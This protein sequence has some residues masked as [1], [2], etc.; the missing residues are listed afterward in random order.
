MPNIMQ[1]AGPPQWAAVPQTYSGSYGPIA[2]VV[3]GGSGGLPPGGGSHAPPA[4]LHALTAARCTAG[5]NSPQQRRPGA[6]NTARQS[7]MQ[8]LAPAGATSAGPP[9]VQGPHGQPA[10]A[11][12]ALGLRQRSLPPAD[13]Q[14]TLGGAALSM[15]APPRSPPGSPQ[16]RT[17]RATFPGGS[18]GTLG[19]AIPPPAGKRCSSKNKNC[20]HE[21]AQ[22]VAQQQHADLISDFTLGNAL[23]GC[24]TPQLAT[25]PKQP[26]SFV[27]SLRAHRSSAPAP[28]GPPAGCSMRASG[29]SAAAP[30]GLRSS[31]SISPGPASRSM[32]QMR[33]YAPGSGHNAAS[34]PRT[35]GVSPTRVNGAGGMSPTRVNGA[36]GH[37]S[38][39]SLLPAYS[40]GGSL[41]AAAG[42]LHSPERARPLPPGIAG[43]GISLTSTLGSLPATIQP[44]QIPQPQAAVPR[45]L[46]VHSPERSFPA[47][48]ALAPAPYTQRA[49]APPVSPERTG[50]S[51]CC[52]IHASPPHST[53]PCSL[54]A[55][56]LTA[57]GAPH[58]LR[59]PGQLS[60][61]RT[62]NP[63][64]HAV[65]SAPF[66]ARNSAPP[67]TGGF[68]KQAAATAN[69][70][71]GQP[72]PV[73]VRNVGDPRSRSSSLPRAGEDGQQ[74]APPLPGMSASSS[75]S[76][77]PVQRVWS[78]ATVP[79]ECDS[80]IFSPLP[81]ALLSP[82]LVSRRVSHQSGMGDS[83]AASVG[84]DSTPLRSPRGRASSCNPAPSRLLS[85]GLSDRLS[86]DGQSVSA[87]SNGALSALPRHSGGSDVGPPQLRQVLN[88]STSTGS[89]GSTTPP[90]DAEEVTNLLSMEEYK[91]REAQLQLQEARIMHQQ[92]KA[93]WMDA[94]QALQTQKRRM[95]EEK[96]AL[97]MLATPPVRSSTRRLRNSQNQLVPVKENLPE[98]SE[99]NPEFSEGSHP[100]PDPSPSPVAP[101]LD[102][103]VAEADDEV[104]APSGT[105][106]L[107]SALAEE[108]WTHR[109]L[110]PA[111][112]LPLRSHRKLLGPPEARMKGLVMHGSRSSLSPC[113][114]KPE[115]EDSTESDREGTGASVSSF[116]E[117]SDSSSLRPAQAAAAAAAAAAARLAACSAVNKKP[118][119]V[120]LG[121]YPMPTSLSAGPFVS[122]LVSSSKVRATRG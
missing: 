50:S 89:V 103:E 104:A 24:T 55:S 99:G 43:Q 81:A 47:P 6:P 15:G 76:A 64:Q 29:S 22:K 38:A 5:G 85:D 95:N 44:K 60:P 86:N 69:C 54:H 27:S 57:T 116:G 114:G 66:T 28:P 11:F 61:E 96:K 120:R 106:S 52:S 92:A 53:S 34:T 16:F 63:L 1:L 30:S 67:T 111:P 48:Q 14:A 117:S 87:P 118:P 112:N 88:W 8:A 4:K 31:C 23:S 19:H 58:A 42:P 107:T 51:A 105:M 41:R 109:E 33:S 108:L 74:A 65:P 78:S 37:E 100:E 83:A 35:G 12:Q 98:F 68:M 77:L 94:H 13:G 62:G 113:S 91:R 93:A 82:T 17:S 115:D 32:S 10:K 45:R 90:A 21:T 122:S 36:G 121:G 25:T 110:R 56:P 20:E 102:R 70:Q 80:G 84:G 97:L 26:L 40:G 3:Q 7:A 49:A 72:V 59:G 101:E 79:A 2:T 71:P 39:S 119:S 18:V 46:G 73:L 75:A 9:A